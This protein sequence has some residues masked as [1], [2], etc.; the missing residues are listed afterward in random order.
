MPSLVC[1]Y[2]DYETM[3]KQHYQMH[4]ITQRHIDQLCELPKDTL[5][6]CP[7]CTSYTSS[8]KDNFRSHVSICKG[9]KNDS[10]DCERCKRH[11]ETKSG[12]SKHMKKCQPSQSQSLPY[13]SSK[14][15]D[16]VA[17][18][19]DTI[20]NTVETVVDRLNLLEQTT[21]LLTRD[22]LK[23]VLTEF[24]TQIVDELQT[25]MVANTTNIHNGDNNMTLNV[26]LNEKCKDAMNIMDFIRSIPMK[27]DMLD[28]FV[29]KGYVGAMS[30][31]MVNE[32]NKLPITQRPLHCTDVRRQTL[33]VKHED[34]WRQETKEAPVLLTAIGSLR[35]R[36]NS[37]IPQRYPPGTNSYEPES[38][39]EAL[40]FKTHQEL[41]GGPKATD[42][43]FNKRNLKIFTNVCK[44]IKLSK[45]D[46]L[47]V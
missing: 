13:L 10:T 27:Q 21:L 38:V 7:K 33:H 45:K 30:N 44:D 12:L 4:L 24:K 8:R 42:E 19:V 16:P 14:V 18:K 29:N 26:F 46:M 1:T 23:Q 43:V 34:K 32:L 15:A 39:Q 3:S 41:S 6:S 22:E 36:C 28:M 11:F 17:N 9:P 5:L 31:I 20:A 25:S 37:L 2:C 47:T 40:Y 35:K